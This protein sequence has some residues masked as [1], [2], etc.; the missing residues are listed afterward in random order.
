MVFVVVMCVAGWCWH[1]TVRYR[2][3]WRMEARSSQWLLSDTSGLCF[4]SSVTCFTQS[5]NNLP[6]CGGFQRF[7]SDNLYRFRV[8]FMKDAY[9][10]YLFKCLIRKPMAVKFSELCVCLCPK[11][12]FYQTTMAVEKFQNMRESCPSIHFISYCVITIVLN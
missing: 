4:D 12:F 1:L 7:S 3:R 6:P 8:F 11:C 5:T 2:E 10:L 9:A